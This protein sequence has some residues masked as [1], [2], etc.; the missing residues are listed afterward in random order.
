VRGPLFSG[1]LGGSAVLEAILRRLRGVGTTVV[2]GPLWLGDALAAEI[3]TVLLVEPEERVRARR[4]AR[5]AAA[6]GRR[7]TV[8]TAGVELPLARGAIDAVLIESVAALD[9][10]AA[11][12]WLSTLIPTLRT[13]GRL[14][15]ADVTDDPAEEARLAAL[16]L[17]SALTHIAQERPRDGV[18]LTAGTAPAEALVRARFEAA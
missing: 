15:A 1:P 14:I 3:P 10:P 7:L 16:W 12:E 5:R 2:I 4:T 8:V 18:L 13:G 9:M 11:T 17:A 6:S